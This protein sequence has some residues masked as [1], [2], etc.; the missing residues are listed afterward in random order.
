MLMSD[1]KQIPQPD[2]KEIAAAAEAFVA[3]AIKSALKPAPD[4][5][6]VFEALAQK[7]KPRG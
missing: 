7:P 1:Q 4:G 2:Q 3:Q 6:N 5:L